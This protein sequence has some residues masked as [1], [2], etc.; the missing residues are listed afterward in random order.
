MSHSRATQLTVTRCAQ[1]G[2]KPVDSIGIS[3]G[4]LG[5]VPSG[6]NEAPGPKPP[7]TPVRTPAVDARGSRALGKHLLSTTSTRPTTTTSP[8]LTVQDKLVL[9]GRLRRGY[10]LGERRTA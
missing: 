5:M 4:S 10:P 9:T 2:D 6:V 7:S 3:D 8:L 1:G